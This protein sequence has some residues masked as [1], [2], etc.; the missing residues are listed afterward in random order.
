[1]KAK[2]AYV[3][4]GF[5]KS[6][7]DHYRT[8]DFTNLTGADVHLEDGLGNVI[9]VNVREGDIGYYI[10]LNGEVLATGSTKQ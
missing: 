5:T 6:N 9:Q 8:T 3:S 10:S 7:L 2:K 1:M 4:V